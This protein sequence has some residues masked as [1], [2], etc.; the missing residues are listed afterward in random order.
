VAYQTISSASDVQPRFRRIASALG[1]ALVPSASAVV[2]PATTP[3]L[4]WGTG[5]PS[6]SVPNGSVALRLD[7]SSPSEVIYFR[8]GGAWVAAGLADTDLTTLAS[9]ANGEGASLVGIEDALALF[10][11]TDVEGA[12]AE[13]KQIANAALAL[14]APDLSAQAEAGNAIQVNVGLIDLNGYAAER[15]Q[16]LACR[17]YD[18]NL[19]AADVAA[20]TMAE[21]GGGTEISTTGK[22]ALL[23][24]TNATGEAILTVTDVSGVYAG[25]VYLEVVPVSADG[26]APGVPAMIALTFA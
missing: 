25:N 23:I 18:A 4:M 3:L 12:L 22:P 9:T 20:W 8:Q 14:V 16:R 13:V 15:V 11:A 6:E 10:T 5:V 2:D 26:S 24:D 19:D 1:I 7:G 17:V 21:T